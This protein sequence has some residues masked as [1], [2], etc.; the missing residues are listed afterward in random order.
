MRTSKLFEIGGIVAGLVLVLFGA[1]AIYMGVDGRA[2]VRD[3]LKQEQIT[4]GAADD[5]AVAKFASQWA[6]EQVTTGT[7]ARAFAQVIREHALESSGGLAYAQMGRFISADDPKN[8][9][10]TSDEAAAL[11]DETGAP[12]SNTA[13]NTWITATALSTALN[14]SYMAEQMALFGIVVGIAL[15]LSGIG[16]IVLALGGALRRREAPE[17]ATSTTSKTKPRPAVITG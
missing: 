5:P 7:Q 6:D 11:K 10:G 12:L 13:R 15:L 17:V 8:P 1:A 14:M 16:F 3:S 9:A 2:T 4:F